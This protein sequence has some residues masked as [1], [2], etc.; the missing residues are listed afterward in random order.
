MNDMHLQTDKTSLD[1]TKIT[2]FRG[3]FAYFFPQKLFSTSFLIGLCSSCLLC[4]TGFGCSRKNRHAPKLEKVF[5]KSNTSNHFSDPLPL[6]LRREVDPLWAPLLP[7]QSVKRLYVK[8]AL[9]KQEPSGTKP[10]SIALA[11]PNLLEN[12]LQKAPLPSK[13]SSTSL[14]IGL[15]PL[16][17]KDNPQPVKTLSLEESPKGPLPSKDTSTNLPI[18]SRLPKKKDNLPLVDALPLQ[19]NQTTPVSSVVAKDD[20]KI[21]PTNN[22]QSKK[23]KLLAE[24]K[25]EG[26]YSSTAIAIE[27]SN[28]CNRSNVNNNINTGNNIQDFNASNINDNGKSGNVRH[29]ANF[30]ESKGQQEA[31][32][33]ERSQK[34]LTPKVTRSEKTCIEPCNACNSASND[35]YTE[36]IEDKEK[37]EEIKEK[38]NSDASLIDIL[39]NRI[40]EIAKSNNIKEKCLQVLEKIAELIKSIEENKTLEERFIELIENDINSENDLINLIENDINSEND[41]INLIEND[42][43]SID[44]QLKNLGTELDEIIT[45]VFDQMESN[46]V[47]PLSNDLKGYVNEIKKIYINKIK[48]MMQSEY[49]KVLQEITMSNNKIQKMISKLSSAKDVEETVE[50]LQKIIKINYEDYEIKRMITDLRLLNTTI[51]QLSETENVIDLIIKLTD[52]IIYQTKDKIK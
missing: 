41:L 5:P 14:P 9:T 22:I 27:S 2:F 44:K 24:L 28:I 8:D 13:D 7:S 33:Y 17:K 34:P 32:K 15:L 46:Y 38:I 21:T 35:E 1:S 3:I 25:P 18:D 43:K 49:I 52:K 30:F 36:H 40:N 29:L 16:E 50:L 48:D 45:N 4:S 20:P 39:Y 42:I 11:Q 12:R 19:G 51:T 26:T 37:T 31:D 10:T 6:R 47:D 23:P